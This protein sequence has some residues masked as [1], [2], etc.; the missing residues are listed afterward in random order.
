[1]TRIFTDEL[2]QSFQYG[3]YEH[4]TVEGKECLCANIN[5]VKSIANFLSSSLGP[6]GLDKL[7]TNKDGDIYV[8]SDG[9]TIL[10]NWIRPTT[11]FHSLFC[12]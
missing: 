6:P 3:D 8:T 5:T 12:G 11:Q 1:M 9:A 7:T 2:G 10:K 4:D